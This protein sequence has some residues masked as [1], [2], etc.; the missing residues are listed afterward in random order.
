MNETL[1]GLSFSEAVRH[2]F[3]KY[4]VLRGRATR[5]EFWWFTLFAYLVTLVVGIAHNYANPNNEVG[6]AAAAFGVGLAMFIPHVA[7]TVRRLHD[8]NHHGAWVFIWLVPV[9]GVIVLLVFT[10]QQSDP[11][12]NRYGPAPVPAR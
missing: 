12:E 11:S 7:V 8:S 1:S 4:F 6:L 10:L 3:S 2:A 9:V 5:S